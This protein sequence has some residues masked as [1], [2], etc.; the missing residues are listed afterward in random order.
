MFRL[1]SRLATLSY[2]KSFVIGSPGLTGFRDILFQDSKHTRLA[3]Q[4]SAALRQ[5]YLAPF[6]NTG[7]YA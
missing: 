3:D 7:L 2:P 1:F 4:I 5:K 6:E